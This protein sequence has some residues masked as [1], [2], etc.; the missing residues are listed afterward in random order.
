MP[1]KIY[2]E[3]D[4]SHFKGLANFIYHIAYQ[5]TTENAVIYEEGSYDYKS[6][7]KLEGSVGGAYPISI[8]VFNFWWL[9]WRK[10]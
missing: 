8:S 7:P 6:I 4:P 9:L 1:F 10:L 5:Q 3:E 2:Q